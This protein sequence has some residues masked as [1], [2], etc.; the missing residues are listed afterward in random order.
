ML[1]TLDKH[2]LISVCTVPTERYSVIYSVGYLYHPTERYSVIYSVG[3]LYHPTERYSVIYSVGYLYHLL[4]SK[5]ERVVT[6]YTLTNDYR[7]EFLI[8]ERFSYIVCR[9]LTVHLLY[10]ETR[11]TTYMLICSYIT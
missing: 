3:Y 9:A 2:S 4:S 6:Q 11:I 10:F 5:Y 1:P 7:M 8:C